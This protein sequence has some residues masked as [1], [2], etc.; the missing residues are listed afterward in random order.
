MSAMAST[1]SAQRARQTCQRC[2]TAMRHV[3]DSP[4]AGAGHHRTVFYCPEC[5]EH[6]ERG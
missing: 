3:G 5:D 1:E 4:P 2:G 6:R